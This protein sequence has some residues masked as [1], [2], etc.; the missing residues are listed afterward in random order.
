M[1]FGGSTPQWTTAALYPERIIDHRR[2]P[3]NGYDTQLSSQDRK[4]TGAWYTPGPLVE[5]I[6]TNTVVDVEPG[7]V[8]SVLD[9]ACGDGRFLV[10]TAAAIRSAGG[11]PVLT[12]VD[13]D[14][15]GLRSTAPA[16]H[17]EIEAIEADALHHEWGDRRFDIVIGNPPFLSQLATATSRD[18]GSRFGGGPYA[19]AAA[20]FVGL[21]MH[22]ARPDGG[23]VGL[24]LPLSLLTAR[25]AGPIRAAALDG[26]SLDWFWWSAEQV[27][28]ASV[29][30]CAI[31]LRRSTRSGP[32]ERTTGD[33]FDAIASVSTPPS[34]TNGHW[35]WLIA[36]VHGVPEVGAVRSDGT[37]GAFA[38]VTANFR[39]QYYGLVGAVSDAADGP[40]LITTGLIDVAECHWG[41]RQTRFAKQTFTAPRV[42][43][44]A[45]APFMQRW[46]E[47]CLV[48]KVLVATQ[49]RV[50][51][52][53]VDEQGEWLPAVP[54]IRVVPDPA[55]TQ[56]WDV[57][58][59]LTSPVASALIAAQSVGSGLSATTVR[60][61][62]R[63]LGAL[64]WPSGP[65]V[66]AVDALRAGDIVGCGRLVDA[67][68]GIDDEALLDWWREGLS[69]QSTRRGIS[70]V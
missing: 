1:Q 56:L 21:A 12:G 55:T 17:V 3:A 68:Y 11:V 64:P 51:E 29:R 35:G 65:L 37:L 47:R 46:A 16:D 9:P 6:V 52:A 4:R 22:L 20:D 31:G 34:T 57:A 44:S 2:P 69:H 36:D 39:D 15:G 13:I 40:P 8:V 10:T 63:T 38:L 23:R 42:D 7:Q 66:D 45:L 5:H 30:T 67:A 28:D 53:V 61:S 19:D 41:S 14:L 27:F 60:V 50:L 48:P 18:G 59:V 62:Q 54:V 24:V 49:T 58:A 25:D 33:T 32:V 70:A 43:R 26:G